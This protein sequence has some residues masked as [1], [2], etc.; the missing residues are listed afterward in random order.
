VSNL[1]TLRKAGTELLEPYMNYELRVPK[2]C[3]NRAMCDLQQMRALIEEI[4]RIMKPYCMAKYLQKPPSKSLF[5]GQVPKKVII[6]EKR[7]ATEKVVC[8]IYRSSTAI[9]IYIRRKCDYA[10]NYSANGEKFG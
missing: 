10:S 5:S 7:V 4:L 2:E 6:F 9:N 1:E 3:G 8:Y